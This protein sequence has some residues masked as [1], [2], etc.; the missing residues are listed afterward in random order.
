MVIALANKKSGE[1]YDR[2]WSNILEMNIY[3]DSQ[4]TTKANFLF[5]ASTLTLLFLLNKFFEINQV[6]A[7]SYQK[8]PIFLLMM[9]S[10]VC[11]LLSM[12]I[13]LPKI[14]L[15][16]KKERINEDVFYYKNIIKFFSRDE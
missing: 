10:L 13:V 12:M 16:S 4:L 2:V 15:F 3:L 7:F 11:A 14:R 9:G 8:I 6:S 1:K 5:S